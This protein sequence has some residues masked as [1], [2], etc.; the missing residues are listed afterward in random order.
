MIVQRHS[1]GLEGLDIHFQVCFCTFKHVFQYIL[2]LA[3]HLFAAVGSVCVPSIQVGRKIYLLCMGLYLMY[4]QESSC[5]DCAPSSDWVSYTMDNHL[6][7]L[8]T[9]ERRLPDHDIIPS[10]TSTQR[11]IYIQI[12]KGRRGEK[13]L[14]VFKSTA[15]QSIHI[16]TL[17]AGVKTLLKYQSSEDFNSMSSGYTSL[18][19]YTPVCT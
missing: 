14:F 2:L 11:H 17:P 9:S 5:T 3:V 19:S 6:W 12:V 10:P 16:S 1:L 4:S 13:M 7:M 15:F 18:D 8:K